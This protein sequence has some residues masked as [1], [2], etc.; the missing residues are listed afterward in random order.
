M[1]NGYENEGLVKAQIRA[2]LVELE[3]FE[4]IGDESGAKKTRASLRAFGHKAEAPR[5]K[6]E[7]RPVKREAEKRA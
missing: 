6:A 5:E 2:L 1:F 4:R 3:G 7:R